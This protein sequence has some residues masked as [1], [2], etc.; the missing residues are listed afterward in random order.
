MCV[1][2][3]ERDT[4]KQ[5]VCLIQLGWRSG[6]TVLLHVSHLSLTISRDAP[7]SHLRERGF[8]LSW[9]SVYL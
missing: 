7:L 3:Q 9:V 2:T 6:Q 8:N 4:N 1:H 5:A